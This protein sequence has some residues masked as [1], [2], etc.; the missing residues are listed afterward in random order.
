M[1]RIHN[2]TSAAASEVA[3]SKSMSTFVPYAAKSTP[4]EK[5][6]IRPRLLAVRSQPIDSR[7]CD[8]GTSSRTKSRAGL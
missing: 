7:C 3:L 1:G 4:T 6:K 8:A 2:P 5:L